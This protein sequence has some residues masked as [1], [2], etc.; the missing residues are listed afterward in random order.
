[1]AS[2]IHVPAPDAVATTSQA[3]PLS[4]HLTAFDFTAFA[5]MAVLHAET[6]R[7]DAV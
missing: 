7:A 2:L 6:Q 4:R 5:N 3:M 1:L